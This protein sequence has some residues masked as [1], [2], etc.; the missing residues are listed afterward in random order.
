MYYASFFRERLKEVKRKTAVMCKGLEN[1]RS[2]KYPGRIIILGQDKSG[3][4]AVVIYAIT[5]RSPSSQARKMEHS[6]DTIWIKPTDKNLLEKGNIDLLIYPSVFCLP[7]GIAVS[8]GKQTVDVMACLGQGESAAEI[9]AFA[10]KNWDYEPDGPT[11]T[12]RISGCV[13][14][15]KKAA[16]SIIKRSPNGKTI[17]NLFE[18]PLVPGKAKMIMTYEGVNLDPLP[19]YSGEP[20]DL[21]IIASSPQEVAEDVY[22][23]L[24]PEDTE[25]DFRVA[26]ASVFSPDMVSKKFH[27][28]IINRCEE[29]KE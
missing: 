9:L 24:E 19:S 1:I 14:P 20:L 16:V 13:L 2:K 27:I 8:N 26:V 7:Q 15:N 12:P 6:Q 17:R 22:K 25:K 3:E 11:F 21:E 18:F 23:A 29:G 10:L 28:H 4:N 5:G